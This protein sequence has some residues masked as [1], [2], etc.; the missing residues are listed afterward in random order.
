MNL[1]KKRYEEKYGSIEP[2]VALKLQITVILALIFSI[3]GTTLSFTFHLL[4]LLTLLIVFH[5]LNQIRT[6]F[7]NKLIKYTVTFGL[8]YFIAIV[9]PVILMERTLMIS[10]GS[11]DLILIIL[12]VFLILLVIMKSII[13]NKGIKGEVILSDDETAVVKTEYDLMAG[14]KPGKYAVK[15]NKAEKGDKVIVTLS[16]KPFQKSRPEE[17]KKIIK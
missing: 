7:R 4:N 2:Y 8:I 16:K 14:L 11:M 9:I 3:L 17:I 6:N 5:S 10:P 12:I 15:N 1:I 13:S